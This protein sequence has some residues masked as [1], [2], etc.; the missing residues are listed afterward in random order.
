MESIGDGLVRRIEEGIQEEKWR[1]AEAVRTKLWPAI[2]PP[3]TGSTRAGFLKS[4]A[5]DPILAMASEPMR[6]AVPDM[7]G[8]T[9][10]RRRR[11]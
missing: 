1:E 9:P 7:T 10:K 5:S 2:T 3:R 6:L 11:R 8:P 4:Q